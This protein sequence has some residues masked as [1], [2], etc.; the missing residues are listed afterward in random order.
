MSLRSQLLLSYVTLLAVSL[1][2]IA[3]ASLVFVGSRPAP[4]TATYQELA[5]LLQGLAARDVLP[6][7]L[8]A[9]NRVIANRTNDLLG[10]FAEANGVRVLVVANEANTPP[11]IFYDSL[12]AYDERQPF[13]LQE[14]NDYT[15]ERL[16]RVPTPTDSQSRQV[17]GSLTDD[18]GTEWLIAGIQWTG[19]FFQTNSNADV[20]LVVADE[21]PTTSLQDVLSEFSS[22]LL[23]PLLQAA[24]VGLVVAVLLALIT[25]R[26]IARPLQALARGA[27]DVAAGDYNVMVYEKGPKEVRAVATAFNQMTAD[28][29]AAQQSQRE[30]LANVSHDLKTPLTSIQGYS[31]AIMDGAAKNPANAAR[32]IHDE[33]GRLNRMVLELTDLAR[34][35]AGRL[36]MKM[37]ALDVGEMVAGIGQRIALVARKKNITVHVQSGPLPHIAGDGDRL[38]QVLENLLGNA[39]KFTPQGGEIWLSAGVAQGGVQIS[40]RDSG[41]GI[42]PADLPRVFERFYQVDKSR[43]PQRGT[44]LGLAITREIVLAHGGTIEAHSEGRGKGT[45]FSIWLPSPQLST[46]MRRRL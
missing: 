29:R 25:S 13:I 38:V 27:T 28:V 41:I 21:R 12:E 10:N 39:L 42:P 7:L 32:I 4:A 11:R 6:R 2:V 24:V 30:F 35:Q 46:I 16:L 5:A 37:T 17:F 22:S 3:V 19:R 9:D 8:N 31:Q 40:V 18:D 20:M 15:N 45:T 1:S 26:G 43:G 36:S 23:P 44:G 14:V 34:L 33:A